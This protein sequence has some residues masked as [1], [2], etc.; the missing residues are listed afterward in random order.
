MADAV[1]LALR[2]GPWIVAAL[3]V[4]FGL[5]E[6]AGYFEEKAACAADLA[7]AR[8]AVETA[9]AADAI[10]TR[11]IE[12]A[13][14]AAIA[15]LKEQA[16]EREM[17]IATQPATAQC[18]ASPAM[19]ALFDGLRARAPA[20]GAGGADDPAGAGA[21]VP[22]R[23]AAPRELRRRS[24][25]GRVARPRDRGR[26]GVP[27]GAPCTRDVGARS[28][29]DGAAPVACRQVPVAPSRNSGTRRLTVDRPSIV[30]LP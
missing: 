30:S 2:A 28:L 16:N 18:T 29:D 12:D 7:A 5:V 9:R 25:A 24:R 27:R 20:P 15:R 22:R 8:A 14:A 3:A 1:S 17:S 19:R 6:R 26:R 11:E 23:T 4:G 13:H 21:A 10:H